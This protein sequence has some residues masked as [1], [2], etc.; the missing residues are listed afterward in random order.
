VAVVEARAG[1]DA[2]AAAEAV[3]LTN[4]LIGV[5]AVRQLDGRLFAPHPLTER[6]A[7]AVDA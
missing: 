5:R 4:A 6:L 3:F 7:G 2:L 1:P